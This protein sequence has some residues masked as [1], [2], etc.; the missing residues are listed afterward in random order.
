MLAFFAPPGSTWIAPQTLQALGLHEGE[1]PLTLGSACRPCRQATWRP[2]CCSPTSAPSRCWMPGQLSRLLVPKAFTASHPTPPAALQLKQGEENNL[3]RLTE[4]FHLNLDAL[5]FLSFVVGLFIVHAAIGLALEQR[6]GLLRTLR[7]CGVS[8]RMLI[9]GLGVEL[10]VLALLGGVPGVAS[11]YLLASLLPDV[12]AS[13]RGLYGA[14]VAG[15]LSLS[16]WWWLSG[17]G[18][19]PA[20]CVA[21]RRQQPVA[22]G[23]FAV[24]GA[25]QRPGLASGPWT[26]VA[27]PGLGGGHGVADRTA[28]A[29]AGDSLASGFVLMA[30]LLLGAALVC[31]CCST[32]C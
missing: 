31:R 8:A 17:A 16:P 28:G 18:L 14:E 6:R 25:G 12:A 10:G 5:G 27:A 20:R 11:G 19:E 23:T 9:L 26:L 15:Q 1:Q 3:A 22:G 7:A 4:S 13:L 32:A 29:V 2:A 30:A 24:A 21:G